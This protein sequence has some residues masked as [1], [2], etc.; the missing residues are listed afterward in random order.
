MTGTDVKRQ[1]MEAGDGLADATEWREDEPYIVGWREARAALAPCV[2]L[3]AEERD[4]IGRALQ[5]GFAFNT[6]KEMA[7]AL[8]LLTQTE[9]GDEE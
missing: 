3:T 4:K 1:V 5:G 7:E 9:A 2:V 6:D 8:A